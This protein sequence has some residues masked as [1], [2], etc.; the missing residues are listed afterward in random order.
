MSFLLS[1]ITSGVAET[2]HPLQ[3]L[4]P[5]DECFFPQIFD[6]RRFAWTG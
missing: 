3:E 4:P 2:S 6:G 5:E 1:S